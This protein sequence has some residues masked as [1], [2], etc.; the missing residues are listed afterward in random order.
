MFN[1]KT[2]KLVLH[3]VTIFGFS[4]YLGTLSALAEPTQLSEENELEWV[5][6]ELESD[7]ELPPEVDG[8][9]DEA[10]SNFLNSVFDSATGAL[11]NATGQLIEGLDKI[12]LNL[13]V[14]P[15]LDIFKGLGFSPRYRYKVNPSYIGTYYTRLD[16]Y[17]LKVPIRPG[18]YLP[19][20]TRNRKIRL[21]LTPGFTMDFYQQFPSGREAR[22]PSNG[23]TPY[24][25]PLSAQ[26]A[27]ERLKPGDLVGFQANLALLM[28]LRQAFPLAHGLE[29]RLGTHV[30]L[31]GT[32]QAY[33]FKAEDELVRLR[34]IALREDQK[35][36][37]ARLG[38]QDPFNIFG[39]KILDKNLLKVAK[40]DKVLVAEYL[41]RGQ[42]LFMIDYVFDLNYQE[43]REAYDEL[44]SRSRM[45][46]AVLDTSRRS[47]NND[48]LKNK[49]ISNLST[50]HGIYIEDLEK[51]ETQKRIDRIFVGSNISKSKDSG[52]R[53]NLSRL[54]SISKDFIQRTS[55]LTRIRLD[56]NSLEEIVEK[57]LITTWSRHEKMRTL[58]S[59][60]REN[61]LRQ[62]SLIAE[63]DE[64]FKPI[65]FRGINFYNTFTDRRYRRGE[66]EDTLD[67]LK[68]NLPEVV[69]NEL[70]E[71]LIRR[72]WLEI[73]RLERNVRISIRH[74]INEEGLHLLQTIDE[75]D[76]RALLI[77]R[78]HF[79]AENKIPFLSKNRKGPCTS[80]N[81]RGSIGRSLYRTQ[82]I[83]IY[84]D[85]IE[86]ITKHSYIALN[87]LADA[88]TRNK[89]FKKLNKNALFKR[90]GPSF[91]FNLMDADSLLNSMFFDLRITAA[92]LETPIRFLYGTSDH[93]DFF[94]S[95]T[96]IELI[97]NDKLPDMRIPGDEESVTTRPQ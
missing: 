77:D 81:H 39:V 44:F 60:V 16:T 67:E 51:E 29:A 41:T 53:I 7:G 73:G 74:F 69:Y 13:S 57:Y 82:Y 45:V 55:K 62:M 71:H 6:I 35:S 91:L 42:D 10:D 18:D 79:M 65:R 2:C 70:E 19:G 86:Y 15:T 59:F 68:M 33:I 21:D 31:Q 9:F 88:E 49:L 94:D 90:L 61:E 80:H 63:A 89:S 37:N 32:F 3:A 40:L 56:E 23:Y 28:E 5:Q 52:F 50:I 17:Q 84:C 25:L 47:T 30:L 96:D 4:T 1:L 43:A 27:I 85:D 8:P 72:G 24:R 92:S 58:F 87:S 83:E 97:L 48:V 14:K 66:H 93:L 36:A 20:N 54:F 34:L 38:F 75:S 78:L 95:V 12:T 76:I 26:K 46:K 22:K 64:N 11:S